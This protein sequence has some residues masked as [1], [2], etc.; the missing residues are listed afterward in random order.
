M[1]FGPYGECTVSPTYRI[2]LARQLVDDGAATVSPPTP[3]SKT[4]IGASVTGPAYRRPLTAA[5]P[6]RPCAYPPGP[7]AGGIRSARTR[8]CADSARS[9]HRPSPTSAADPRAGG[10]RAPRTTERA[11]CAHSP[12]EHT[13]A[14]PPLPRAGGTCAAHR[15]SAAESARSLNE[16]AAA[17]P[18]P[19]RAGGPCAAHR[20]ERAECARSPHEHA[21]AR[22]PRTRTGETCS[23]H[24]SSTPIPPARALA[25]APTSPGPPAYRRRQGPQPRSVPPDRPRQ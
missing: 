11:E 2:A 12:H 23:A 9:P 1:G 25:L 13:A 17:R 4:P 8:Q 5:S 20:L 15:S 7:R 10:R 14:R 3:L 18:P 16:H 6:V 22:P 21:A 24:R 19:P